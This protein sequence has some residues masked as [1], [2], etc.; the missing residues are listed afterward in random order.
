MNRDVLRVPPTVLVIASIVSTQIGASVAIHLFAHIGPA[1]AVL[2]RLGFAALI[3]L[4]A[5]RPRL[6]GYSRAAY[7]SAIL[8]GLT[9]AAMNII[10]Y[11][12]L[13]RIPLGIAVTLEFVGP[14]AVAIAGSRNALDVLWVVLAAI[15]II[16]ITPWG[17][18]HLDL[19]GMALA[20][21]A[22]GL[23]A[24]YIILSAR[25]GQDFSG[26]AGLVI[27]MLIA[28]AV[29]VPV[30]VIGGGASLLDARV[31]AG[32]VVVAL[33]SSVVTYS[34]ELSALRT[35][36]TRVFGVLM[37]LEPAI[38]ALVGLIF[39]RET[40]GLRAV[41]AIACVVIASAGASRFA[42]ADLPAT[43]D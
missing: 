43:V 31:L 40:L 16:L 39:L 22:G 29:T 10:F 24:T 18:L 7:S 26:G 21:T 27:A 38:A 42:P 30:G 15:G 19:L 17:G 33:L 6:S 25:V 14:L 1:G 37:S 4:I 34:F 32:G 36:S 23:W 11:Q 20:L 12:A 5:W 2:L 28:A 9:L 35:M 8:F 3:L 13:N 41:I